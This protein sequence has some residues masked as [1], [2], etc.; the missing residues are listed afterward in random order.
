MARAYRSVD[1]EWPGRYQEEERYRQRPSGVCEFDPELERFRMAKRIAEGR[2][3]PEQEEFARDSVNRDLG[4]PPDYD[5]VTK[6]FEGTLPAEEERRAG[7]GRLAP[8]EGGAQWAR[9]ARRFEGW[10]RFR[11]RPMF[12]RSSRILAG[13]RELPGPYRGVGPR[14]YQRSDDQIRE[15]VCEGLTKAGPV[16]ASDIDVEV[17][18]GVVTLK[19]SVADRSQKRHAEDISLSVAGVSDVQNELRVEERR[20]PGRPEEAEMSPWSQQ[21]RIGMDVEDIRGEFIGRIKEIRGNDFRVDRKFARDVYV[22]FNA[23]KGVDRKVTVNVDSGS[24]D[25]MGWPRPGW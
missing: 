20:G 9:E 13:E 24:I 7:P 2:W 3:T 21:V 4:Q 17:R 8:G 25:E 12:S 10:P 23:V 22:P 16:D 6:T 18:N 14:G 15:D 1:R 19:G 11:R 5:E